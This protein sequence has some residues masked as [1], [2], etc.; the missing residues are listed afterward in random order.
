[1]QTGRANA[2]FSNRRTDRIDY[3]AGGGRRNWKGENSLRTPLAVSRIGSASFG[4]LSF[5]RTDS[6]RV[7]ATARRKLVVSFEANVRANPCDCGRSTGAAETERSAHSAVAT[8]ITAI[9]CLV[10]LRICLA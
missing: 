10:R 6:T 5:V 8:T 3:R 7:D 9:T 2:Q 1:M 4:A